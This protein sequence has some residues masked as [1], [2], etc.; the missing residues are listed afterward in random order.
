M[1][2][3]FAGGGWPAFI[4]AD[5]VA[6]AHLPRIRKLFADREL[7]LVDPSTGDLAAAGWSVPLAWDGSA[8]TLPAGY[9]DSLA[10]ALF[11]NDAGVPVDTSVL[12]AVQV[13]SDLGRGGLATRLIR[14]LVDAAGSHGTKVIAP[15][16]PTAKHLHPLLPIDQYAA[17]VRP[18][19]TPED[20]WLRTH[21]A[22]GA[23]VIATAPASQVFVAPVGT[24]EAWT[25]IRMPASGSYPVPDAL[26]PVVVDVES[27]QG[28]LVEP[29]IWVRHR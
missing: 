9:S 8:E 7:A 17:L 19:G 21:L 6:S 5:Q 2:A 28:T 25:G 16:R 14:A 18:D 26:A 10:R 15:L 27:G 12:C 22:M 11:D 4:D 13:R 23:T 1:A 29:C 20:P 24:W 3:L